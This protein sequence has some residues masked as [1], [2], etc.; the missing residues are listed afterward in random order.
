M[1]MIGRLWKRVPAFNDR[2]LIKSV[3]FQR[4][5]KLKKIALHRLQWIIRPKFDLVFVSYEGNKGWILD[6]ICKEIDAYFPGKTYFHYSGSFLPP[7][8][9][10]FFSHHS[11]YPT[12]IATT[13]QIADAKTLIWYTH[14]KALEVSTQALI[15]ALNQA[16]KVICT[17]SRYEKLLHSQGLDSSKTTFI[18]GA[19][20][21]ELFRPHMR[22]NG[23]VGFCTAYYPRKDPDRIL[24]IIRAMPHRS[25][26]LL[27]RNWDQYEQYETLKSLANLTYI[28]AGYQDYPLYYAQMDVF[29]SAS[30]LEGGP[31]PLIEAMMCNVF[32]VA[33]DTGFSTDIIRHGENGFIFDVEASTDTICAYIEQAFTMDVDVHTTVKHLSWKNFSLDVQKLLK[34]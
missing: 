28:E 24:N 30:R 17:C 8:K 23:A 2:H 19:A 29:V 27:G 7:A 3:L 12:A 13:P 6:A 20:D 5:S 33:S 15:A 25:F 34:E 1:T 14:P 31:I 16:T 22:A 11:L 10:Y 4:L 21:P 9:A 26:I 32:P 18:I